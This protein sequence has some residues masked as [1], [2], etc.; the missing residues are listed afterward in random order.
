[1]DALHGIKVLEFGSFI[2]APYAAMILAEYGANVIKIERP[3]GG[4]PFRAFSGGLYSPQF[5]AYNRHKRSVVLDYPAAAGRKTL[6]ALVASADVAIVNGRPGSGPKLG[7]DYDTLRSLNPRLIYC[8]ITGFGET[9]PYSLRPAFDNVGQ[10]LS[11]W[12]S[13]FRTDGDARVVGPAVSDAATG[14]T[15]AHGVMA[16]LIRRSRDGSG[17]RVE[18]NMIE[19]TLALGIEPLT[20][21]L[22]ARQP[23]PVFQ[24]AANS[25]AYT[26]TCKDG[27]RIG[28][29][30][31][32]VDKFWTALCTAIGKTEW[33]AQYPSR[34]E[35]V[36]AYEALAL[37]LA[38]VFLLRPRH[39]WEALLA[40]ADVPFAPELELQDLAQDP[41]LQHLDVFYDVEH[42]RYGPQRSAHRPVRLDGQRGHDILPAP[43]LGEH[44]VQVLLEAGLTATAIDDLR[45]RG[46][47]Q[48]PADIARA[49]SG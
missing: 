23:V 17:A 32:S 29:H 45:A 15:A 21:Y 19:S 28:L 31:S 47:V 36:K 38:S 16:S 20:Q 27:K 9:G 12:M 13:R 3:G 35:R 1:M 44:T 14:M 37:S 49:T 26:L 2:T 24:R 7:I 11:G 8:S 10:A 30:L 5:Q 18:V 4:D 25:Q 46:A 39:E 40:A 6:A 41:Q 22:A 33:I 48:T 43:D 42:P 34:V